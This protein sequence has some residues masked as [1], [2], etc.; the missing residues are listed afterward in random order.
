MLPLITPVAADV[1]VVAPPALR[2]VTLTRRVRPA[3]AAAVGYVAVAAPGTATQFAPC[4]SH[5][6]QAYVKLVGE[7]L[8]VPLVALSVL[9]TFSVPAIVG[10]LVATGGAG[11]GGCGAAT[12]RVRIA[13][14]VGASVTDVTV[15]PS[16]AMKGAPSA[17]L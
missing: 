13:A 12:G 6:T 11:A 5:C 10:A 4:A 8:H 7:P 1:A 14:V 16:A 3:S 2:A 15:E 9:P 17:T